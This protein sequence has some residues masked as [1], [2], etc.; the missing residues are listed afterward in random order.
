MVIL[1]AEPEKH[2][3]KSILEGLQRLKEDKTL[4]FSSDVGLR[5]Y[6]NK[7]PS[8]FPPIK[9]FGKRTKLQ[10]VAFTK[11]SPLFPAFKFLARKTVEFGLAE[12]LGQEWQGQKLSALK[13]GPQDVIV[14]TVGQVFMKFGIIVGAVLVTCLILSLEILAK[15]LKLNYKV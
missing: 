10:N 2:Y 12:K 13:S 1:D 8:Q 4:F 6:R 7:F 14:L 3:A 9:T 11:N 5:A 15:K